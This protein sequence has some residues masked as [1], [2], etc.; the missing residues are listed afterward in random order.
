MVVNKQAV[1]AA[2]LDTDRSLQEI[3]NSFDLS[4]E[5]VRQIA[6]E[7]G[8]SGRDR[9]KRRKQIALESIPPVI[10]DVHDR[11]EISGLKLIPL[12][13]NSHSRFSSRRCKI[14]EH[15]VLVMHTTM[16]EINGQRYLR[17]PSRQ[18]E[19]IEYYV[20]KISNYTEQECAYL[21]VPVDKMPDK[22]TCAV[23][24]MQDKPTGTP[25]RKPSYKYDSYFENWEQLK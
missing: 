7:L 20:I 18:Q 22:V 4:H 24:R 5:R 10:A 8:V 3:A 9:Q 17:V 21:V 25:G 2:I 11:C 1:K 16:V 23:L 6:K 15:S 12:R 14:N 19:N 13:D